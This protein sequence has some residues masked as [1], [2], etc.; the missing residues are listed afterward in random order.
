MKEADLYGPLVDG[1]DHD[2]WLLY[3][4]ADGSVGF[5]PF[6]LGGADAY[7]IAVGLEVKRTREDRVAAEDQPLPWQLFET[8]QR[9]W[10]NEFAH[11]RALALI[12]LYH[13]RSGDLVVYRLP[14][15]SDEQP[16][17]D[18][19]VGTLYSHA[20]G[21]RGWKQLQIPRGKFGIPRRIKE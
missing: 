16:R 5:K 6:D 10:L 2:N 19:R 21:Y 9:A 7:G 15:G 17:R 4:I 11:H 14:G 20:T 1:A 12:V 8:R 13:D 3:R 18:Y